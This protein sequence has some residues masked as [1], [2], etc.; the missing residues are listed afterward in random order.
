MRLGCIQGQCQKHFAGTTGR[1][2]TVCLDLYLWK[3]VPPALGE[4]VLPH[5]PDMNLPPLLCHDRV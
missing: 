2:V 1:G 5:Q 3:H 4:L